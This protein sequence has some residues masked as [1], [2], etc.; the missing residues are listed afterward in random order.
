[1]GR[2]ADAV[3]EGLQIAWAAARLAVKN[4]ILV[5]T[6]ARGE[7]FQAEALSH[8]AREVMIGLAAE[9]EAAAELVNRQRKKAWGRHSEPDGTHDYRDRDTRNLRRRRKQYVGVAKGLREQA[10][11]HDT[12][13]RLVEEARESA[14]AD[15][16]G[17]LSRRLEV[18]GMRAD[19]DPDYAAM[20]DARMTAVTMI[21][22]Q[23]L[24][25]R[26]RTLGVLPGEDEDPVSGGDPG[27][28]GDPRSGGGRGSGGDPDS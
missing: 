26:Q 14:W 17:N 22:L 8:Y 11:D 25:A 6:I 20:R 2:I 12:V 5:E 7:D 28:G 9:Q 13:L 21:D 15:V 3:A 23:R 16:E 18:E 27:S 19:A 4:I 1:M 24:E 10:D